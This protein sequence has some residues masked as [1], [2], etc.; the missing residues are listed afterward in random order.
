M[1]EYLSLDKRVHLKPYTPREPLPYELATDDDI[2]QNIGGTLVI[3]TETYIN[4]FLI[5]MKDIKT[6]KVIKFETTAERA[7]NN[8][9][10]S[11]IMHHYRTV[12]FNGLKY[13]L[14]LI[15]FAY[16]Y[17]NN[18]AIK[19][20]SDEIIFNN[21]WP[22]QLEKDHNFTIWPTQHIDLI[23]VCPLRG[24]LKLYGAR[25]HAERIQDLPFDVNQ[26]LDDTEVPI[27][28]DYC[29]SDLN[30][31]KLLFN[32]L[33]EQLQLRA[34]LSIQYRQDLMSKSDA[35]IAEAVIS[36]E[37]KRLTG[38]WP[39]KPKI[40]GEYSFAY[41][42]PP[43]IQ[44]LTPALKT[45]LEKVCAIKYS[46]MDTGR[47]NKSAVD[48]LK[49]QIGKNVYRMGSGGLH[50][51]EKNVAV[52]A[53]DQHR[54]FD[55]DVASYYPAIVLNCKLYPEHLGE[56]FLRVYQTIVDRRI[57]AKKAKNIAISE[58][59]K[60]CINGTFGK[61]GSPY[62]VL[63]AP[64]MMVQI[65]VTGQLA[66]LMLIE[67]LELSNIP[68]AS[69]NTDGIL[70]YC[71]IE[72]EAEYR[73]IISMWEQLTGFITEETEYGAIYS[74][75]VNAYIAIK[76]GSNEI[77]GKNLYY[78]PWRGKTARDG[79]WRFQ[80]NPN[81]QICV[82]AVER[83]IIDQIPLEQ[84][85]KECK[86]ITKF[87]AVK[88]VTGGAHKDGEYLGR[89]IRWYYATN[90][91]GTINYISSGNKVPD[92]ESAKP[93]MDLPRQFPED[94]NYEWYCLKCIEMLYDMSYIE[95]SKQLQ[96]FSE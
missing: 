75:D 44:F 50:S 72:K 54:L 18:E 85:I 31:T 51:S 2:M 49:I 90:I 94:I 14:P 3:D 71:P 27:V 23:E 79:Y 22:K 26:P 21:T 95:R 68:V 38:K 91:T 42:P 83:F 56:N 17:E 96:F 65:T 33:T 4:Y 76:K 13:D 66:L 1:N 92:T 43:F 36:S 80:K 40:D 39:S 84:T 8:K 20:L 6:D 37:L 9:K 82:E 53:D 63:Y 47:L 61:T 16:I 87:V 48:E 25:L 7:F 89:V 73:S 11:W 45:V 93:C 15:W 52:K 58:C 60:I 62:S 77:K 32:N 24:S 86:D 30:A 41:R 5:L 64:S 81:T 74:R 35:Q 70:I 78:D 59:L 12:S 69:A 28:A 57:A 10:M 55:R 88:N 46:L 19:K 29:L 34:D 67:K